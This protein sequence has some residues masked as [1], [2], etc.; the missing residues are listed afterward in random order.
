MSSECLVPLGVASSQVCLWTEGIRGLEAVLW[1]VGRLTLLNCTCRG[2]ASLLHTWTY[3]A[4][5]CKAQDAGHLPP[6]DHAQLPRVIPRTSF[7]ESSLAQQRRVSHP[8]ISHSANA[9]SLGFFNVIS[10]DMLIRLKEGNDHQLE[11]SSRL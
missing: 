1:E 10:K 6:P 8:G 11:T 7:Q 3:P 9:S 5:C 4:G 2:L